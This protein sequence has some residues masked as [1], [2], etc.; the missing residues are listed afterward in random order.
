[1]KFQDGYGSAIQAT[2]AQS[3]YAV[4]ASYTTDNCLLRPHL[5]PDGFTLALYTKVQAPDTVSTLP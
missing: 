2:A 5:C 1:M 3:Q 4:L